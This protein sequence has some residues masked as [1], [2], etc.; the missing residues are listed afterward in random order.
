MRKI[1]IITLFTIASLAFTNEPKNHFAISSGTEYLDE[2]Y[3]NFGLSTMFPLGG[4]KELDLK[5]AL[6]MKTETKDGETTPLFN[7]P[8][9]VGINFLFP[10]SENFT[11]L[12]GLGLSPTIR[13]AGDD[14]GFLIGPNA[15]A[16]VR[17]KIHPTMSVFAEVCQSLLIGPP[18]WMYPS[19]EI[20]FGVNFYL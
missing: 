2:F 11:F 7:V 15:K 1:F 18:N 19:T 12:T 13:L 6:N 20:I 14:K 10:I 17:Y 3:F 9:K 8:L 16:G 5:L 4:D